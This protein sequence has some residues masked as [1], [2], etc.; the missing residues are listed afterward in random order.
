[1]SKISR[2]KQTYLCVLWRNYLRYASSARMNLQ[3][4]TCLTTFSGDSVRPAFA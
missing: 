2:Q 3:L 1:M 4:L